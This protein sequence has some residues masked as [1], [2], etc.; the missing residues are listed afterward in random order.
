[1][2]P[3]ASGSENMSSDLP[4]DYRDQVALVTGGASGIGRALAIALARRGGRIA[5]A[6]RDVAGMAQTASACAGGAICLACD[7]ADPAAPENLVAQT[8]GA[9]GR[10]DFLVS[11]AGIGR[12]K[13][14]LREPLTGDETTLFAVNFWA[15]LRLAQAY[16]PRLEAAGM[17]GRMMITASENA[18]SV[19]AGVRGAGLGLYAA[20]KHAVLIMAE[21]LRDET[22]QKPL[23]LHVLLPGGVFTP[24]I[25]GAIPDITLAPPELNIILPETCAERALRGVDLGLFYIPTQ[26]H[27]AAD[28]RARSE[29]IAASLAALGLG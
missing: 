14:L 28:M 18:L 17:R 8:Y 24:L 7:L 27:L 23:D 19:P 6:D 10:L 25:A 26:A 3:A 13:R 29:G 22:A 12:N 5:L 11:N 21:W 15:A 16:V 4:I 2:T 9:L 20:S 1:M